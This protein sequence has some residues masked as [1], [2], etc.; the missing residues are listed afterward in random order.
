[1]LKEIVHLKVDFEKLESKME[2]YH[3][4]IR[5]KNFLGHYLTDDE[6]DLDDEY[7]ILSE[8]RPSEQMLLMRIKIDSKLEDIQERLEEKD[9]LID[10]LT[11][12]VN[13]IQGNSNVE[14]L[15]RRESSL[16]KSP[17]KNGFTALSKYVCSAGDLETSSVATAAAV[18][19]EL[20]KWKK[21]NTKISELEGRL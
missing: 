4:N 14:P 6:L 9:E 3:K 19:D 8:L 7:E 1:M 16:K 2:V 15:V 21:Q 11:E 13:Q 12:K 5:M 20:L 10:K 18:D 17:K